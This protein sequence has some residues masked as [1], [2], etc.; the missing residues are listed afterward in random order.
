M[1]GA[2]SQLFLIGALLSSVL[3]I[4]T[5]GFYGLEGWSLFDSFYMA[6]TTLSTVGYFEIIH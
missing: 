6:L 4:G 3:L 1:R 2:A 5:L